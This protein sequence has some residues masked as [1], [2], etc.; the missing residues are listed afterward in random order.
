MNNSFI[1][2]MDFD[3][4]CAVEAI[5][6]CGIWAS[7]KVA[8]RNA[9]GSLLVR[10]DGYGARYDRLIEN[11]SEIRSPTAAIS[12]LKRKRCQNYKVF[13]LLLKYL[14]YYFFYEVY[15]NIYLFYIC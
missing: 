11:Q 10:F 12:P 8:G 13:N 3:V 5:D 14:R 2:I 7:G 6:E 4:G 1:L 9:D 15:I